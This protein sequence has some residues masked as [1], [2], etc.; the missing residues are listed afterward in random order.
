MADT[1]TRLMTGR[2]IPPIAGDRAILLRAAAWRVG[3]VA[4]PKAKHYKIQSRLRELL[5]GPAR[6]TGIVDIV[7]AFRAVPEYDL[8]VADVAFVSRERWIRL[9]RR[10]ISTAH[11]NG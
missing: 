8:R 6:G 2:R 7:L 11:R 9:I 10:T 1:T 4:R 5:Q 3:Q